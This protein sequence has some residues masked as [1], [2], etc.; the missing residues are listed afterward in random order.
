MPR[1]NVVN[2]FYISIEL[3]N[4]KKFNVQQNTNI[5]LWTN[6][7][8]IEIQKENHWTTSIH[9]VVASLKDVVVTDGRL[10]VKHSMQYCH[11]LTA[12]YKANMKCDRMC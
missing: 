1:Q 7:I 4:S 10:Y 6:N 2:D 11:G 9:S 12:R 3:I 8:E 5:K